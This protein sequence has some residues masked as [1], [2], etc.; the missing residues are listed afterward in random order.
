ML[1]YDV[2]SKCMVLHYIM[3]L[4]LCCILFH[5][6]AFIQD[7]RGGGVGGVGGPGPA[8]IAFYEKIEHNFEIDYFVFFHY[9]QKPL[10]SI[11]FCKNKVYLVFPELGDYGTL[12]MKTVL[13]VSDYLL[14][15]GAM[16][17]PGARTGCRWPYIY[18]I[19]LQCI[20]GHRIVLHIA[21]FI[22]CIVLHGV[23]WCCMVLHDIVL[24]CTN[25]YYTTRCYMVL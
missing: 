3:S 18:C 8:Q 20:K 5:G 12:V 10:Y 13:G 4:A 2:A 24:Q 25:L 16:K 14:G 15:P 19:S 11:C 6:V 1:F 7:L 21:Y 23:A 22:Y 9:Y 17:Y